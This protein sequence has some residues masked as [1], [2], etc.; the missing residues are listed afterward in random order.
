[1]KQR[2][3][4]I[5]AGM[6]SAYLLQAL[7]QHE[8]TLDISVIG[9]EADLCYDRIA[10]SHVLAGEAC[11]ENLGLLDEGVAR[12]ARFLASTKVT[13]ID[14]AQRQV[15]CADGQA[16]PFDLLVIA[17]GS[18]VARP[19]INVAG[20]QGVRAFRTLQD[21]RELLAMRAGGGGA[22]VVGGGLLGLEAAHGL[23]GLGF[24]TTVVHRNRHLMNRQLDAEAAQQLQRTLENTG[25]EFR[26]GESVSDLRTEG[27]H[28][29]AVERAGGEVIPCRQLLFATGIVPNAQLAATAGL[30]TDRGI[31]VDA[32]MRT[33]AQHVYALGECCQLDGHCFGLV[34]PIRKQADV[35][36]RQLL[37]IPASSFT[38]GDW[39]TQLKIS[40][41]DIYRA[42]ELDETAEQVVLR[43]PQQGIYRKLVIR[44]HRLVGAVLVGDK[45]GGSWYADLIEK[46]QNI[47][48]LRRGLMFGRD[49][50][51][52]LQSTAR[53]T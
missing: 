34:A 35:L 31:L 5:G 10:L 48:A 6:A 40:G 12:S 52:A 42:G 43:D 28:L 21:V 29:T 3:V 4:I 37:G 11:A 41:I 24:Q 30:A 25:L 16:L 39:P 2:L 13:Q 38:V 27:D 32:S 14:L 53:A 47:R 33:S 44:D 45:Q 50:A 1:M 46:K 23:N 49:A 26:L 8:S 15:L 36:A 20:V 7:H 17:T 51:E 9:E 18:Q 22:V 19:G